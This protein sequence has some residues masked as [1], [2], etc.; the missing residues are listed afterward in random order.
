MQ[1]PKRLALAGAFGFYNTGDEAILQSWLAE[2]R[3]EHADIEVVVIGGD[4]AAVRQQHD[5]EA[6]DWKDWEGTIGAVQSADLLLV[7][8]GGLFHDYWDIDPETLLMPPKATG[9]MYYISLIYLAR[10]FGTKCKLSGVGVGPLRS[11]TGKEY[12][13]HAFAAADL[14]SVRDQGSLRWLEQAGY[15][16]PKP[17]V[18]ADPVYRLSLDHRGLNQWQEWIGN[19]PQR[20]IFGVNVR[21]WEIGVEFESWI[22]E[23]AR[24]LDTMLTRNGGSVVLVPFQN[25]PGYPYRNDL[26]ACQELRNRSSMPDRF[27]SLPHQFL[28]PDL[29]AAVIGSC[30]LIIG[31]RLH[32]VI[33]ALRRAKPVVALVYDP[34]VSHAMEEAGV[35]DFC[36]DLSEMTS[37][38]LVRVAE[39]AFAGQKSLVA[40]LQAYADRAKQRSRGDF[41]SAIELLQND[42]PTSV[43]LP[44]PLQGW[45]RHVLRE[46][47]R[48]KNQNR[49]ASETV[50]N[51]KTEIAS[52]VR[53]NQELQVAA[54]QRE[55]MS[56]RLE[57]IEQQVS[58][59]DHI[60]RELFLLQ[61][62]LRNPVQSGLRVAKR[63][64]RELKSRV[65]SKLQR[66]K[67][68]VASGPNQVIDSKAA[69]SSG[70]ALTPHGAPRVC[71][72]APAFF[73]M[74]GR[75]PYLGGA[76][77]YVYELTHVLR[78]MGYEPEI[79]QPAK[80][81]WQRYFRDIRITGLDT[82]GEGD[83]MNQVFHRTVPPPQLTIYIFFPLASPRCY[84]PSIG[85]SHGVYWDNFYVT[86]TDTEI[87]KNV[88]QVINSLANLDTVISVDT[89]TINWVRTVSPD[90][91][92]KFR[93]LPNFVDT[94]Q[95]Q[96][97]AQK[98]ESKHTVI[99]FPRRIYKPRGSEL[100]L[101]AMPTIL[102][103]HRD[104]VFHVVGQ[105]EP[106]E[107]DALKRL[108]GTYPGRIHFEELPP[109]RMQEAY[110]AADITIIPTVHSEGTSLSCLEAMAC[111]NAVVATDVGGLPNIVLNRHNGLLI[112]PAED[113]LT[114]ALDLLVTDRELRERLAR[115][116]V[117]TAKAFDL[118]EWKAG[119]RRV[120]GEYLPHQPRRLARRLERPLR[121]VLI[122]NPSL[123]WSRMKLRPHHL[124]E[125]F[126]R[127][128]WEVYWRH[129][130]D[131]PTTTVPRL[132]FTEINEPIH[133]DSPFVYIFYPF[134]YKTIGNYRDPIVI[135]DL[136]D[137]ISIHDEND[138]AANLP[139]GERA[140]DYY[141]QLLERADIVTT[142]S[143]R[144]YEIVNEKRPDAILV[145]NG[146]DLGRFNDRHA[147]DRELERALAQIPHPRIG[148]H[149]AIAS[150]FDIDLVKQVAGDC[151]GHQFVF[152]GPVT[153]SRFDEIIA[154]PN[155]HFL[156]EQ[157]PE[158]IPQ[159]LAAIDVS[160]LTFAVDQL[161]AGVRPHKI[162]EA[163]AM[164]RPVV[165]T[166]LPDV[167]A[168][169]YVITARNRD[170]F[171]NGLDTALAVSHKMGDDGQLSQFL[172]E[173]SWEKSV[174]PLLRRMDWMLLKKARRR[175]V[176]NPTAQVMSAGSRS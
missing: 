26:I 158:L 9:P 159:F 101:K 35:D 161:T 163:L 2:L 168:W 148:F 58:R 47:G 128:G 75:V 7:A 107:R 60:E 137:D 59:L 68:A 11:E 151:P 82:G 171:R 27:H 43:A 140:R 33:M 96:P 41:L 164:H 88:R 146:I 167:A 106:E 130:G 71:I 74:L 99:L 133:A 67:T 5:V 28:S 8:G 63:E 104:V 62:N 85:I 154:L 29:A 64:L 156:G 51:L 86:R 21:H 52:H 72:V 53:A 40:Q 38:K 135:Y 3:A 129:P 84:R 56:A 139:A 98:K 120:L 94:S 65:K 144:L 92:E 112:R 30:D 131:R 14:T 54:G 173:N 113:E 136:L 31:M 32:S 134:D 175:G 126:A 138:A 36:L 174:R 87:Q 114:S 116:A 73:D 70:K 48:L 10:V 155:C 45:A 121:T 127:G 80:G 109:E 49:D 115:N 69:A 22:T 16:G 142:S 23:V 123:E 93:Y 108:I 90:L 44:P 100:L 147:I 110:Q 34:K 46:F 169:P 57:N 1:G 117:T 15:R 79:Y 149:G 89:N 153:N 83:A 42:E 152:V 141:E 39:R 61:R 4:A 25:I 119:W 111:G 102:R 55:H 165:T 24:A 12:V 143:Q 132:H 118:S 91:A 78:E 6:I 150:W 66:Q 37:E 19:N 157:P 170:E 13:R 18:T 95:F 97:P 176:S 162:L 172:E 17:L 105:A 103:R 20:P 160:M 124:A 122:E 166:P 125:E 77:R 50:E 145:P 81:N 76:E